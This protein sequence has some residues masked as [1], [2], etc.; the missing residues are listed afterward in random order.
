MIFQLICKEKMKF[1]RI[2]FLFSGFLWFS[3]IILRGLE[4]LYEQSFLIYN[5][6]TCFKMRPNYNYRFSFFQR[7]LVEKSMEDKLFL[8]IQDPEKYLNDSK[9]ELIKKRGEQRLYKIFGDQEYILKVFE[10]K[11]F[12]K[13]LFKENRILSSVHGASLLEQV[14]IKS[15]FPVAAVLKRSFNNSKGYHLSK[16]LSFESGL[17]RFKSCRDS[18]VLDYAD[19]LFFDLKKHRLIHGDLTPK[20]FMLINKDIHVIDTS[21]VHFFPRFSLLYFLRHS[22]EVSFCFRHFDYE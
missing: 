19:Y 10:Q 7:S 20:N 3:P 1:F 21:D 4:K 12:I 5:L 16:L 11:G 8:F 15:L 14:N 13:N 9:H 2:F 18:M 6:S 22:R 17:K